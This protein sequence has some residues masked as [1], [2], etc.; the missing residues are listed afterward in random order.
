MKIHEMVSH[1]PL[2][3]SNAVILTFGDYVIERWISLIAN[4]LN[5]SAQRDSRTANSL[6]ENDI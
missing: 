1:R 6:C 3:P 5:R 2:D 4:S